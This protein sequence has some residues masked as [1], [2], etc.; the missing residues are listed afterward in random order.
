MGPMI[1]VS[2]IE[3]REAENGR[4]GDKVVL[5]LVR[6]LLERALCCLRDEQRRDE[7]S[8]HKRYKHQQPK[9]RPPISNTEPSTFQEESTYTVLGDLILPT[10]RNWLRMAPTLPDAADRP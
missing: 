8:E 3:E 2:I 9:I 4:T 6:Q 7:A 5:P 1:L 10:T